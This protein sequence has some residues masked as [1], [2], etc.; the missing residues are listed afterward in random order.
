MYIYIYI[1]SPQLVRGAG[2]VVGVAESFHE[3]MF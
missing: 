2:S 1:L 3:L